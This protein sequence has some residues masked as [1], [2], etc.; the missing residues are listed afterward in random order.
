M[1]PPISW[2]VIEAAVPAKPRS[3]SPAAM[4]GMSTSIESLAATERADMKQLAEA[5]AVAAGAT[6]SVTDAGAPVVLVSRMR[7]FFSVDVVGFVGMLKITPED[8]PSTTGVN[9]C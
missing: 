8:V 9:S 7:A 1:T 3:V 6:Y 4:V 5:L 2:Q